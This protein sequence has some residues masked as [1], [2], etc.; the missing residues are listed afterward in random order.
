MRVSVLRVLCTVLVLLLVG[1]SSITSYRLEGQVLDRKTEQP[2][3]NLPVAVLLPPTHGLLPV[4]AGVN[5]DIL[6]QE[7]RKFESRTDAAGRFQG[8]FDNVVIHGT[9]TPPP[10][11]LVRV[12]DSCRQIWGVHYSKSSFEYRPLDP[13]TNQFV[14]V[15]G[16][17]K[18][19]LTGKILENPREKS[20]TGMTT[21]LVLHWDE[22]QACSET[23]I[24]RQAGPPSPPKRDVLYFAYSDL[25]S[26]ALGG[27]YIRFLGQTGVFRVEVPLGWSGHS[28]GL[29]ALIKWRMIPIWRFMLGIGVG[30][31][32]ITQDS[33]DD[34]SSN[35]HP[36]DGRIHPLSHIG[37]DWVLPT[38]N[39][40]EIG[41]GGATLGPE[42]RDDH[43]I[44]RVGWLF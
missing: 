7:G 12:G 27:G 23:E 31:G 32:W 1:C 21:D 33:R 34:L 14:D 13:A 38:G 3:A 40:L 18:K 10:T 37:V 30:A 44:V 5:V 28:Y 11:Y 24:R 29:G 36:G 9:R 41:Y 43:A 20:Q 19:D 26:K 4:E 16:E 15:S 22:R 17:K 2:V 42:R 39:F 35:F 6:G 8:G 25:F